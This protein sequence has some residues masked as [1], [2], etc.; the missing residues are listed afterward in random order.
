MSQEPLISD[1]LHNGGTVGFFF[2]PPFVGTGSAS[3]TF[4]PAASPTVQVDQIDPSTS[5]VIQTGVAIFTMTSGPG[6]E[7]IRVHLDGAPSD[8]PSDTDPEGYFSARWAT[9]SANLAL[10]GIYRVRVLVPAR[11]GSRELGFADVDVVRNSAEF[12]SVAS[13]LT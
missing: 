6:G 4:V 13:L 2:L 12:R 5:A 7:T 10:E 3:G 9:D 8:L 1:Q 11:S